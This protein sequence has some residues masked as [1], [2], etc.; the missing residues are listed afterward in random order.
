[1]QTDRRMWRVQVRHHFRGRAPTLERACV[2]SALPRHH[3]DRSQRKRRREKKEKKGRKEKKERKEKKGKKERGESGRGREHTRSRGRS[4]SLSDGPEAHRRGGTTDGR[5]RSEDGR[6]ALEDERGLRT[7]HRSMHGGEGF[8]RGESAQGRDSPR[9]HSRREPASRRSHASRSASPMARLR[10]PR[11][12]ARDGVAR[13][14]VDDD[15]R[16]PP[17]HDRNDRS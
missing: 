2:I 12:R 1:M 7:Q 5:M 9:G 17:R 4:H 3:Q 15:A 13:P 6:Q 14:R 8:A 10:E 16:P 11:E